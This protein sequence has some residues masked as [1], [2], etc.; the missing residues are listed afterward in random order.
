LLQDGAS[1]I[2]VNESIALSGTVVQPI[3]GVMCMRTFRLTC[4]AIFII[5]LP[6]AAQTP[7][8]AAPAQPQS[9]Q[10]LDELLKACEARMASIDSI[11]VRVTRTELHPLTKNKTTYVGEAAFL[12]P[13]M[14]RIDLTHQDEVKKKDADK[15]N[16][17]RLICD[18]QRIYEYVPKE[19]MIIVHE[20]PKG[21]NLGDDNLILGFLKGLKAVA[22]KQRFDLVLAKEDEWYSYVKI[23]PKTD[24]DRQDFTTSRLVVCRKNP[25]IEGE[26]DPTMLPRQISYTAP[27][28]REVVYDFDKIQPNAKL[29]KETFAPVEIEGYKRKT[30][31]TGP[32]VPSLAAPKLTGRE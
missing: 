19:K 27:N 23:T 12:K 13:N 2:S 22:A 5:S 9:P 18:G 11:S 1:V 21:G 7:P 28:G 32:T 29:T 30:A 31:S 3:T 16:F 10:R 17:E 6:L 15:T 25:N 26:G 8:P 24:G 14:A 4:S 20:M